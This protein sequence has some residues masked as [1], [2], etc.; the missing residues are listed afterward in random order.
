MQGDGGLAG[1]GAALH[2]QHPLVR[3][4]DDAVLLG[5]DGLHD[6]AHAAGAGG[7]EGGQQDGVAGGVLVSGAGLVAEVEDLVVQGGDAAAVGGEVPAAAQA[8]RGVAGGEVEGAGDVGAPVDQDRGAFGVVLPQPDP[9]DVVDAAVGEVEPAEAERAVDG[10]QRG[11][12]PRALG[13][14]DVPLQ[15]GLHGGVALGERVRDR[16]LGRTAQSV[17]AGIQPVDEFLLAPQF[18]LRKAGV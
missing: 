8:H 3:G 12:Q 7:V 5:L 4:A 2:D 9:A 16:P 13:D 18:I 10:V 15:A 6:V 11:Q 17:H 1:A 14:E